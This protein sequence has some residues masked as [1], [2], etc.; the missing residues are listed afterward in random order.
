MRTVHVREPYHVE[1]GS[2]S[3][4]DGRFTL[5]FH[6]KAC[7]T[8]VHLQ[9]WWVQYIAQQLWKIIREQEKELALQKSAM[10]G[11]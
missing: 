4:D 6:D 2:V 7:T 3:I 9:P 11:S 10:G 5:T 1:A 8:V